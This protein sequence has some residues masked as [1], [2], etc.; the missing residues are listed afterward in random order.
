MSARRVALLVVLLAALGSCGP[1]PA[2]PPL[3]DGRV[4]GLVE[5]VDLGGRIITFQVA[6]LFTDDEAYRQ[7]EA[8]GVELSNPMYIRRTGP[9]VSLPLA[10]EASVALIDWDADGNMIVRT[11]APDEG[12]GT[13]EAWARTLACWFEISGGRIVA[14][15]AVIT[16]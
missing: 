10:A 1:A 13:A 12:P 9:T 8:D 11:L 7:A 3:P 5:H 15:E 14:V 2:T 6:E 16:P 4:F